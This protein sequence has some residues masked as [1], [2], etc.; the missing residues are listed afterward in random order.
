MRH[1]L[2][3]LLYCWVAT[4]CFEQFT[5]AMDRLD[6]R[7]APRLRTPLEVPDPVDPHILVVTVTRETFS[8]SGD[9]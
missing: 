1:S 7:Y 6:Q 3:A 2:L 4:A 8:E 5:I 9:V